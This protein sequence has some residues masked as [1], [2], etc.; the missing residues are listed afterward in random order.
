MSEYCSRCDGTQKAKDALEASLTSLR[1][2][3]DLLE[4]TIAGLNREVDDAQDAENVA[5]ERAEDAEE[6]KDEAV[7]TLRQEKRKSLAMLRRL[8]FSLHGL[9]PLCLGIVQ[10]KTG[11]DLKLAIWRVDHELNRSEY[12]HL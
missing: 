1:G 7:E 4:A 5:E 12:V 10:H 6:A 9:C 3:K 11:C 2:E 8:E